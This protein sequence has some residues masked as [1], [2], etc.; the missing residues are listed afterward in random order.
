MVFQRPDQLPAVVAAN[1]PL[2][3]LAAGPT[4]MIGLNVEGRREHGSRRAG[5]V[6]V[7]GSDEEHHR[8]KF[9]ATTFEAMKL[10]S[11]IVQQGEALVTFASM[12]VRVS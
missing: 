12:S 10:F 2:S 11:S 6:D 3:S 5:A 7:A 4:R 8:I 1:E 9:M